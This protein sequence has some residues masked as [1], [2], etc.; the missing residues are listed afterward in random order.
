[1]ECGEELRSGRVVVEPAG[2]CAR[3]TARHRHPGDGPHG[4]RERGRCGVG[5]GRLHL[6]LLGIPW[7]AISL[8]VV[9]LQPTL[10]NAR[11]PVTDRYGAADAS[12]RSAEQSF[13]DGRGARGGS[14]GGAP[15]EDGP[16]GARRQLSLAS[17]H[18]LQPASVP[19]SGVPNLGRRI[20]HPSTAR[21]NPEI[22]SSKRAPTDCSTRDATGRAG[23]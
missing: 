8:V 18:S 10:V 16:L 11:K 14:I 4:G 12:M 6:A 22:T 1:M 5:L 23:R 17:R 13:G 3:Q 21:G 19:E 20:A 9:S 7:M 2:P 15:V